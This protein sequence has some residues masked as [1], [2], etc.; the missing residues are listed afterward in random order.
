MSVTLY[1]GG[2]RAFFNG[3]QMQKIMEPR[4]EAVRIQAFNNAN[5][6]V[7]GILT[8]RLIENIFARTE[9]GPDGIQAVVGTTAKND[10]G[11]AYPA[12]WDLNGKPWL[13]EAL[14]T[15]FPDAER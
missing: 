3:P 4:A 8:S 14:R 10:E 2:L 15:F 6:D 12:Y 11:F 13:F 9:P 5:N 7:I 1:E